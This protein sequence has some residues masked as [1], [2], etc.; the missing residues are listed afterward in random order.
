MLKFSKDG[1]EVC[2][3]KVVDLG[4]MG[5]FDHISIDLSDRYHC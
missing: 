4:V 1:E 3:D 2:S 5:K